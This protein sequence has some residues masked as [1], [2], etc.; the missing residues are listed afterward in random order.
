[1]KN[2]VMLSFIWK[3]AERIA[4]QGVSFVLSI[5]LARLLMPEDYGVVSIILV[6]INLA[7]VFVSSGFSTALIQDAKADDKDYSTMMWCSLGVAVL[8]YVT[9]FFLAP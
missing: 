5:I 7:N 2:S 1:M 8:L 9:L 6:F 3:F 4:A